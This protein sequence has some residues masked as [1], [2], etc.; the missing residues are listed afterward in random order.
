MNWL[1]IT[2]T[3]LAALLPSAV[4]IVVTIHQSKINNENNKFQ[5]ELNKQN[6]DLKE[7]MY[8][9]EHYYSKQDVY[10]SSYLD[11]LAEYLIEPTENKLLKYKS[12]MAKAYMYVPFKTYV[13]IE[14]IDEYINRNNFDKV[15]EL[16]SEGFYSE[17]T[18]E[19]H[20]NK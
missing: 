5:L 10:M 15:K 16:L 1:T 14:E 6:N 13:Q 11:S 7:K 18:K 3:L 9:L 2:T 8:R 12:S 20:Q 4:S 17:L 19:L